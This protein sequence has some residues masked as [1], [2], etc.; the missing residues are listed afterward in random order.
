MK[1]LTGTLKLMKAKYLVLF[2]AQH[3]HIHINI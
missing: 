1:A 2:H 3:T